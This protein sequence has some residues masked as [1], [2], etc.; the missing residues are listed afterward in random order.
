MVLAEYPDAKGDAPTRGSLRLEG[1]EEMHDLISDPREDGADSSCNRD[2]QHFGLAVHPIDESAQPSHA[3]P[4]EVT[5]VALSR[6]SRS[7]VHIFA[8][9]FIALDGVVTPVKRS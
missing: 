6:L 8:S 5:T 9:N 4:P 2:P 1:I 3:P 7:A